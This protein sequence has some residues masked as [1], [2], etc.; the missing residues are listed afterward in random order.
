MRGAFIVLEGLDRSGKSTQASVLC[1]ALRAQGRKVEL[2]NYPNRK[3]FLGKYVVMAFVRIY[4]CRTIDGYLKNSVSL[5]DEAIHLLFSANRWETVDNLLSQLNSGV[6]IVCDRYAYS[7][8]AYSSAKGLDFEWC[9]GP[10]RGLPEPD[11][12]LYMNVSPEVAQQRGGY[13][14]ERYEKAEFQTLVG[15]Q[16]FKLGKTEGERWRVVN[17]DRDSAT[18]SRE[19]LDICMQI[20]PQNACG[21]LW[22]KKQSEMNDLSLLH[23]NESVQLRGRLQAIRKKGQK[24]AFVVLRISADESIQCVVSGTEMVEYVSGLTRESVVD[25]CGTVQIPPEPIKGSYV[26]ENLELAVSSFLCVDRADPILP[27]QFDDLS[28]SNTTAS[29]ASNVLLDTRLNNRVLDLRT[30]SNFAIFKIQANVCASFRNFFTSQDFLEIHTPK[31]VASASEGGASVFA[32]KSYFNKQSAYLAQSPQFYKQ[33]AL[34]SDFKKV[35]EIG[36]VFRAENSFTHRHL[37]EFTGLDFEM[38]IQHTYMEIVNTVDSLFN[39]IFSNLT[40]NC[41]KE[42]IMVSKQYPFEPIRWSY[43]CL[44][45]DFTKAIRLLQEHGCNASGDLTTSEEKLL[46]KIVGD[47]YHTD[48]YIVVKFPTH[49]RPFYTMPCKDDP[50]YTNSYDVYLRGEEIMSGSQRIHNVDELIESAQKNSVD[51]NAISSYIDAFRYGSFSHGGGGI[52]LER[53]VMLFLG[54]GNVRQTS[55]FPRDPNRLTP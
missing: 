31:M 54:L 18:I 42:M 28:S 13:G 38:P 44:K 21:K 45:L 11:L 10:D 15:K 5:P 12:V 32:L 37:T 25:V 26:Y 19:V 30:A 29:G 49:A 23:V 22:V 14:E 47:K 39:E 51:L 46:G 33:M 3:T 55:M 40:N 1:E 7:G 36:S 6:D 43:P 2:W 4:L 35:F 16:F 50:N 48:F 52:G 9:R 8:I 24:L 34:M 17:A 41:Q 53:V 27:V 20:V